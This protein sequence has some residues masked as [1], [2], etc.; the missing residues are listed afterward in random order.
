[1]PLLLASQSDCLAD[2]W[3]RRWN[4]TTS[5]VLR[6]SVYDVVIDGCLVNP[7]YGNVGVATVGS[8]TATRGKGV[9]QASGVT[10]GLSAGGFDEQAY[11]GAPSTSLPG[12][13]FAPA[14]L[15]PNA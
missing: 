1:M 14:A 7:R 4:I 2:F 3:A 9:A 15:R 10:N 5:S 13:R 12:P 8:G 11:N 6:T